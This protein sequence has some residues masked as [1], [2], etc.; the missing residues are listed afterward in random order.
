MRLRQ[1]T[2]ATHASN[3]RLPKILRETQIGYL[4]TS[5]PSL[6]SHFSVVQQ[7]TRHG[8]IAQLGERLHGMQEVSGSIPLT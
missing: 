5:K 7:S 2:E 8:G 6:Q 1:R 3:A 4:Q